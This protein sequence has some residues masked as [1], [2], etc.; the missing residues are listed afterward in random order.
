MSKA[1]LSMETRTAAAQS[2]VGSIRTIVER[3]GEEGMSDGVSVATMS[4]TKKAP[5]QKPPGAHSVASSVR[6][7]KTSHLNILKE[8]DYKTVLTI[9]RN[10]ENQLELSSEVY[11]MMIEASKR[12]YKIKAAF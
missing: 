2:A 12:D 8:V 10:I 5:S 7:N 9:I 11:D 1:D 3:P 6:S 4:P